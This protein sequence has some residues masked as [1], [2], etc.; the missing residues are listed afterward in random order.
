MSTTSKTIGGATVTVEVITGDAI[1]FPPAPTPE[2]TVW[3]IET[4]AIE[5]RLRVVISAMLNAPAEFIEYQLDGGAWVFSP[6]QGPG[7]FDLSL[8]PNTTYSVRLRAR[9]GAVIGPVTDAKTALTYLTPSYFPPVQPLMASGAVLT[10]GGNTSTLTIPAGMQKVGMF[11]EVMAWF[12]GTAAASIV[13]PAGWTAVQSSFGTGGRIWVGWRFFQDGDPVTV[14]FTNAGKVLASAWRNV[15]L[16][17]PVVGSALS[18]TATG[19]TINFPALARANPANTQAVFTRGSGVLGTGAQASPTDWVSPISTGTSIGNLRLHFMSTA[20]RATDAPA[21]TTVFPQSTG[22]R[23]YTNEL[24]GV[25][26]T[27]EPAAPRDAR[28]PILGLPQTGI[29]GAFP[30]SLFVFG[31]SITFNKGQISYHEWAMLLGGARYYRTPQFNAGISGNTTTQMLARTATVTGAGVKPT[32]CVVMGG[33][34]DPNNAVAAATT[35][36][37]LRTI[38]DRFLAIGCRVIACTIP[39]NANVA[40]N[41]EA[42]RTDVNAWVR[43]QTDVQVVDWDQF[44]DYATM[45]SDGTHPNAYGARLMGQFIAPFMGQFIDTA[46]I[47]S[48]TADNLLPAL[49]GTAGSNTGTTTGPVATGW[50]SYIEVAGEG[51]NAVFSRPS[52][53][54]QQI[55]IG[56]A[57]GGQAVGLR[58]ALPGTYTAGEIYE[59]WCEVTI[60]GTGC[61]G[62]MIRAG[63]GGTGFAL[64][65]PD[66]TP[67]APGTYILRSVPITLAANFETQNIDI[68][69]AAVSS[70]PSFTVA[71]RSPMYR[72]VNFVA[73]AVATGELLPVAGQSNGLILGIS[74]ATGLPAGWAVSARVKLWK[75]GAFVNYDPATEANWGP[76]VAYA[77]R[78]LAANPSPAV[79]YIVKLSVPGAQLGSI[80]TYGQLGSASTDWSETPGMYSEQFTATLAAAKATIPTIPVNNIFWIQGATDSLSPTAL[81][82]YPANFAVLS[83]KMRTVWGHSGTKVINM[84]ASK[85]KTPAPYDWA[86]FRNVLYGLRTTNPLNLALN[87]L[88]FVAGD[89]QA[90]GIHLSK[91]SANIAGSAYFDLLGAGLAPSSISLTATSVPAGAPAGT[92]IGTLSAV[93][94]DGGAAPVFTLNTASSFYE[95]VGTELRVKAAPTYPLA[96]QSL[97]IRATAAGGLFLDRS[98]NVTVAAA[99]WNPRAVWAIDY[100]NDKA[101]RNGQAFSTIAAFRAAGWLTQVTAT[102]NFDTAPISGLL[103]G[104]AYTML[105]EGTN[106]AADPGANRQYAWVID[107]GED[108][109]TNNDLTAWGRT[110]TGATLRFVQ[111]AAVGV[112]ARN[113]Q[114][115]DVAT[116]VNGGTIKAAVSFEVASFN[117]SVNGEIDTRQAG[118]SSGLIPVPVRLSLG[119]IIT[120]T[121]AWGG[122]KG[123]YQLLAGGT[124]DSDLALL[125]T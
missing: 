68:I 16:T 21:G 110:G 95:I 114:Q 109:A 39:A 112:T 37:N 2:I 75:A 108:T 84:T 13:P 19:T 1:V 41:N 12:G 11:I 121:R 24:G 123:K 83:N 15:N 47:M 111:F 29:N 22:S 10:G 27:G 60:T 66:A 4:P 89:Y 120:N 57:S 79:L 101:M 86:G 45:T 62:L 32:L 64:T 48:V 94:L 104:N 117:Q 113:N 103:G 115:W 44:F 49:T 42:H 76:E 72:R 3:S 59:A 14:T 91:A 116:K 36:T 74:G 80:A 65:N 78:W 56:P 90:D 85:F 97:S 9:N 118:T 18:A 100:A 28:A 61:G 71:I 30:G 20:V 25:M 122:T 40:N 6:L 8:T 23:A 87:T 7:F 67:L 125:T 34:N 58:C 33:T 53:G 52:E 102:P 106:S 38:W 31:D 46:S 93:A 70:D 81:A 17:T 73:R 51:G 5:G 43:T 92:V 35:K 50:Q 69:A 107:D 99:W 82:A 88:D 96:D 124:T 63:D 77:V 119:D 98:F 26:A 54:V 105:F 55:T